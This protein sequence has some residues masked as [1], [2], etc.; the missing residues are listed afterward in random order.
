M[1]VSKVKILTMLIIKILT[2]EDGL[3]DYFYL[4]F[5]Y[6]ILTWPLSTISIYFLH[7]KKILPMNQR[8]SQ[9]LWG[10]NYLLYLKSNMLFAY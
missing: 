9:S 10:N 8:F 7:I 4:P 3:S 2:L 5:S 1:G 6:V